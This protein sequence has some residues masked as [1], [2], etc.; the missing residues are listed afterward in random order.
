MQNGHEKDVSVAAT[1]SRIERIS[2][3]PLDLLPHEDLRE[4]LVELAL[5]SVPSGIP[6]ESA[7]RLQQVK[8]ALAQEP[9]SD[10]RVVVFGGGTG[11]ATIVGGDSR[12]VSWAKDPFSGLKNI[13]P[14][15]R[16][17]VCITDDG[18]STGELLKDLPL[19]A[20][21]DIRH[22][23]LSSIQLSK[24]QDLY[25]LSVDESGA[26][27]K[28]LASIFN[29]RFSEKPESS[30]TLLNS[31]GLKEQKILPVPIAMFLERAVGSLFSDERL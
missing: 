10:L 15:T 20:L 24:L 21:G 8:E 30:E 28:V 17:I 9:V 2:L 25:G 4:K 29:Y 27:V 11:L 18:G 6:A 19:V 16:S 31:C 5:F 3:S 23:L 14:N 12:A 1:L 26:C 13:F 7:S 22:V